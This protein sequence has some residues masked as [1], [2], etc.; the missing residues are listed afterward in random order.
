M[1]IR[2]LRNHYCSTN[3]D[4]GT[5]LDPKIQVSSLCKKS[6]MEHFSVICEK[7]P[8]QYTTNSCD[9]YKI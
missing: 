8:N 2:W 4:G 9:F 3:S 6:Q 1:G 5:Y 7:D